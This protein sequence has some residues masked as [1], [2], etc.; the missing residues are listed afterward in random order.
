MHYYLA[1]SLKWTPLSQ[2]MA[3]E[4][5]IT[6]PDVSLDK[7]G[8]HDVTHLFW[9]PYSFSAQVREPLGKVAFE[10]GVYSVHS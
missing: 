3:G 5:C 9:P 2:V 8:G 6:V 7:A 10:K 4:W 1:S